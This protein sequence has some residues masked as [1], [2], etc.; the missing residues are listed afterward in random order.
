MVR[1]LFGLGILG[2][3]LGSAGC[4][5]HAAQAGADAPPP[6]VPVVKT[7]HP[8][9][10]TFHRVIEQPAWIDPFEVTRIHA[11]I[12]GFVQ[13][14]RV[15]NIGV[16]VHKDD[17]LAK[18]W[19]PELV[20]EH[21]QKTEQVR[22]A[23]K[24]LAVAEA[25]IEV[26]KAQVQESQAALARFEAANYYWKGQSERF[27][28]I[29]KSSEVMDKQSVE[30]AVNQ[31]RAAIA[32]VKEAEAKIESARASL[33]EMESTRDK[34]KVDIE[35]ARADERRVAA[36]LS[37][38]EIRAPFDGI[39]SARHVHTG[40]FLQPAVAGHTGRAEPFFVVL[41][42]DRVRVFL[43]VPEAEAVLIH[44]GAAATIRVPSLNNRE[45]TGTVAG[46]SWML[47]PKQRTLR[48]EIDFD[49]PKELLRPGMYAHASIPV[50]H[51]HTFSLPAS[52]VLIRDGQAFCYRVEQGKAVKTVIRIGFREGGRVEVLK[53]L[54]RRKRAGASAPWED[55]T[56]KER[57]IVSNP[58]ELTDGQ[59]V[60]VERDGPNPSE[61]ET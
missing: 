15:D 29:G 44:D 51:S 56:G 60:Q 42:M 48:T 6:A 58:G 31:Y 21:K 35:V 61:P 26:A 14:V 9:R 33:L 43:D 39:V 3:L 40:H 47:E 28:R 2:V 46:S 49:N 57:I 12:S 8:E 54:G 11:K 17:V 19:V 34:A 25:R 55:W 45:F 10:M 16:R 52:A 18:L 23:E 27:T 24:I 1:V 41:R 7:V 30:E 59:A 38:A 36:L 37:Y 4:K 32:A 20:E 53:K 50:E 13:E 5:R 22:Q